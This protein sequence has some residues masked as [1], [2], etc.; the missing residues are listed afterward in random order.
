MEYLVSILP[1]LVCFISL[2][3]GAISGLLFSFLARR[4]RVRTRVRDW[5]TVGSSLLVWL[6]LSVLL[7]ITDQN[8]PIMNRINKGGGF[9]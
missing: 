3:V 4:G 5:L 2:L 9:S 7:W 6:M 8:N 1:Y